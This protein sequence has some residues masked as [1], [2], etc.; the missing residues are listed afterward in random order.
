MIFLFIIKKTARKILLL[1]ALT[2]F[3]TF[4]LGKY[5][6]NYDMRHARSINIPCAL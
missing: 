3:V 4:Q 1:T 2:V 5:C 6:A